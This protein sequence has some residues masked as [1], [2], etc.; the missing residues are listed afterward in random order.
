MNAD[1][2]KRDERRRE[3]R[4]EAESSKRNAIN[5]Q[6]LEEAQ[7]PAFE[8]EIEDCRNLILFFQQRIGQSGGGS[9][10]STSSNG[11]LFSR[12]EVAGVPKLELRKVEGEAPKGTVLKKKGDA[13]EEDTTGWGAVGGGKKKKGSN[14]QQQEKK[15]TKQE[16]Q[17]LNLPFGT[18]A[19]LMGLGITAPLTSKDMPQSIENLERKKKYFVDNQVRSYFE[20]VTFFS[21]D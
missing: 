10:Q 14:K 18:L 2:A 6:L 16:D 4:R 3:E 8:R 19:A 21:L 5:Q 1:R 9:E 20:L 15:E 13:V 11:S 17:M 12:P 7:A